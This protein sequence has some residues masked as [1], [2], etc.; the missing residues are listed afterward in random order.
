[1]GLFHIPRIMSIY[2]ARQR[3][4]GKI[5][6]SFVSVYHSVPVHRMRV[7]TAN[8]F[9]FVHL[10]IL[11]PSTSEPVETCSYGK[12]VGLRL[13]DLL[14]ISWKHLFSLYTVLFFYTF[15]FLSC[16]WTRGYS[17]GWWRSPSRLPSSGL[18][19]TSVCIICGT[20][21]YYTNTQELGVGYSKSTPKGN[22]TPQAKQVTYVFFN[23][24]RVFCD[25]LIKSCTPLSKLRVLWLTDE[26][27][28]TTWKVYRAF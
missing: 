10:E 13:R 4:C 18:L 12:A 1:M 24:C 26:E 25:W 22:C 6:S 9:K 2:I 21:W 28:C 16:R 23:Y 17:W 14:V 19:I 11:P 5:M 7:T 15:K 3:S 27:L 8:L 20:Y